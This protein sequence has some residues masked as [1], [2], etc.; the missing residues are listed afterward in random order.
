MATAAVA[1]IGYGAPPLAEGAFLVQAAARPRA[2]R[3]T[4]MENVISIF[5]KLEQRDRERMMAPRVAISKEA[6]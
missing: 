2:I 1:G 4:R 5:E 6:P 3:P